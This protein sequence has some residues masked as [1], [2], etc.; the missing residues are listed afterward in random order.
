MMKLKKEM[1]TNDSNV[2]DGIIDIHIHTAPDVRS[3]LET[4]IEAARSAKNEHM[5]GV[6]I[7]SHDEP[8]SGR[9][10][11]ASTITNFPVYG[12][13]VLNHGVGGLNP[14]AVQ[15]CADM[16]GKFVW[17]PTTSVSSIE[18]DWEKIEEIIHLAAE[19]NMI[20]LTGHLKPA[21]IL[22]LIDMARSHGIWKLIVNHPLTRV[23]GATLDEQVEMSKYAYLEHCFVACMKLHDN[24]DPVHIS[25]SIR[26][27][28]A[29]RC[30]LATDFGQIHNPKPVDGMKMYISTLID[31]GIKKSEIQTM[32]VDNPKK[33]VE[34]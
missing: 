28:G 3:R 23:V 10:K 5:H 19:N 25:D 15:S 11:I 7:K 33:L 6:V 13:V 21:N 20:L 8:T 1:N 4:D 32:T 17:F 27:V 16:G 30:I 22:D 18:M 12:G 29:N 24:L 34:G 2:L 14:G 26:K 9:A 31:K